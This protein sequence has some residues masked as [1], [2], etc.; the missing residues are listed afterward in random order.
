MTLPT[1]KPNKIGSWSAFIRRNVL[2]GASTAPSARQSKRCSSSETALASSHLCLPSNAN[3]AMVGSKY[4]PF[5]HHLTRTCNLAATGKLPTARAVKA[6]SAMLPPMAVAVRSII[7]L[8]AIMTLTRIVE[9]M[10][11]SA[12]I[13]KWNQFE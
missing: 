7:L 12:N 8:D 9:L 13:N 6:R 4:H 1:E 5:Q 11:V 3:V 10:T 2:G